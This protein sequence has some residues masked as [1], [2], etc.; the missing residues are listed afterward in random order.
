M[1][2]TISLSI[3]ESIKNYYPIGIDN[4]YPGIFFDYWGIKKLE[5]IV[6]AKVH[7][8]RNFKTEWQNYWENVSKEIQLPIIGTTSGQAPSFSSYIQLKE[9]KGKTCDYYE[10]LH[11]AVS[12]V[13]SFYTIIGQS[14]TVINHKEAEE[15]HYYSAINRIIVSPDIESQK[16][17]DLI[18]EKIESK[19][20]GYKFVPFNINCQFLDGLRVRYRDDKKNRIYH[21]LFND[22]VQFSDYNTNDPLIMGDAYYRYEDWAR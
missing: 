6:V 13:G 2:I 20:K 8:D 22:C 5:E 4:Q 3:Y 11:F 17:F 18:S 12:F 9:E 1:R 15:N 19:Y 16:Y 7:N 10:E 14:K 21:A